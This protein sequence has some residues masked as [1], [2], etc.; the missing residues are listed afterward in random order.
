MEDKFVDPIEEKFFKLCGFSSSVPL[1]EF[2]SIRVCSASGRTVSH[3]QS[4]HSRLFGL[5]KQLRTEQVVITRRSPPYF[6]TCWIIPRWVCGHETMAIVPDDVSTSGEHIDST[7]TEGP[8]RAP[9]EDLQQ[10]RDRARHS[11]DSERNSERKMSGTVADL[12]AQ[13]DAGTQNSSLSTDIDH[14]ATDRALLLALELLQDTSTAVFW[15]PRVEERVL[16]LLESLLRAVAERSADGSDDASN[17]SSASPSVTAFL[18]LRVLELLLRDE[19]SSAAAREFVSGGCESG[20]FLD[21]M[22]KLW[23]RLD[24]LDSRK[25][26]R[27]MAWASSEGAG[28]LSLGADVVEQR[29]ELNNLGSSDEQRELNLLRRLLNHESSACSPEDIHASGCLLGSV[30]RTLHF[31]LCEIASLAAEEMLGPCH[32]GWILEYGAQELFSGGSDSDHVAGK[33]HAASALDA[34]GAR[35]EGGRSVLFSSADAPGAFFLDLLFLAEPDS[36]CDAL[37]KNQPVRARLLA[38]ADPSNRE[39]ETTNEKGA[40]K[41]LDLLLNTTK[42]IAQRGTRARGVGGSGRAS[43]S[44]GGGKV[45]SSSEPRRNKSEAEVEGKQRLEAEAQLVLSYGFAWAQK[46]SQADA[47]KDHG[48]RAASAHDR[49]STASARSTLDLHLLLETSFLFPRLADF[50]PAQL[51]LTNRLVKGGSGLAYQLLH[52]LFGVIVTEDRLSPKQLLDL[53]TQATGEPMVSCFQ[54]LLSNALNGDSRE[55][56]A[57]TLRIMAH[58]WVRR[59]GTINAVGSGFA[60]FD[61]LKLPSDVQKGSNRSLAL[62]TWVLIFAYHAACACRAAGEGVSPSAG[63][64]SSSLLRFSP[65]VVRAIDDVFRR[66]LIETLEGGTAESSR[67]LSL[68]NSSN[69]EN[70]AEGHDHDALLCV[71]LAAALSMSRAATARWW[72]RLVCLGVDFWKW[73]AQRIVV[74]LGEYAAMINAGGGKAGGDGL[75]GCVEPEIE[76]M[77]VEILHELLRRS[78]PGDHDETSSEETRRLVDA[79][80]K[81]IGGC[82]DPGG[83]LLSFYREV[84]FQMHQPKNTT[85]EIVLEAILCAA[86]P[87]H[88]D[89]LLNAMGRSMAAENVISNG[90]ALVP[91]PEYLLCAVK[92]LNLQRGKILPDSELSVRSVGLELLRLAAVCIKPEKNGENSVGTTAFLNELCLLACRFL[93]DLLNNP[94]KQ[95]LFHATA[96]LLSN[97]VGVALRGRPTFYDQVITPHLKPLK[98]LLPYMSQEATLPVEPEGSGFAFGSSSGSE[99]QHLFSLLLSELVR[100]ESAGNCT[101]QDHDARVPGSLCSSGS[102]GPLTR[103]LA[104]ANV[105]VCETSGEYLPNLTGLHAREGMRL[106]CYCLQSMFLECTMVEVDESARLQTSSP[107]SLLSPRVGGRDGRVSD[108]RPD[109]FSLNDREEVVDEEASSITPTEQLVLVADIFNSIFVERPPFAPIAAELF[110]EFEDFLSEQFGTKNSFWHLKPSTLANRSMPGTRI[111]GYWWDFAGQTAGGHKKV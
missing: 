54:Q 48:T 37:A 28:I 82:R 44:S 22:R 50:L 98:K 16:G 87:A 106:F 58:F 59:P 47:I 35:V 75:G 1:M 67:P 41:A 11:S 81:L 4:C 60:L 104:L 96:P 31:V 29:E 26:S 83:L 51:V 15:T 80:I 55:P 43:W 84:E 45:S 30:G 14:V 103:Y 6:L 79:W 73:N 107:V 111:L 40:L 5:L 23:G 68:P 2:V 38:R 12:L 46:L 108:S 70:A 25:T 3:L 32:A 94:R 109:S 57:W 77:V 7:T 71:E 24:G 64:S 42:C 76:E 90:S 21:A 62:E 110:G 99:D 89:Q 52:F 19:T 63:D 88:F 95:R 27:D 74:A 72:A 100:Q 105:L 91:P 97:F 78:A 34:T 18:G 53:F 93:D 33:Q 49:D 17:D 85:A 20:W 102:G 8:P 56:L 92:H 101:Q 69:N 65:D 13:L 10:I 9:A 39:G 36:F 66:I 61:Q 86:V